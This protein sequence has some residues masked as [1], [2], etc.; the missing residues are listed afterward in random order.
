MKAYLFTALVF[1]LLVVPAWSQ[2]V[3]VRDMSGR[4][5]ETWNQRGNTTDVRNSNNTL[6]ETRTQRGSTIEVRDVNGR[7]LRTEQ[8]GK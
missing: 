7:L 8:A 2:S 6:L 1:S 3:T 4:L 5:V